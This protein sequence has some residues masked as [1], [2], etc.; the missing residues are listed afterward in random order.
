MDR[1]TAIAA[2]FAAAPRFEPGTDRAYSNSG[3]TLLAAVIEQVTGEEYRTAVRRRVFEPLGM[4]RSGLYGEPLWVDGNVAVGRGADLYQGNDPSRWPS[5]TWALIGNGGLV[6]TL[7][8]LMTLAKAFDDDS[9]F[10]SETRAAFRAVDTAGSIGGK[11]V[12]GYAGGNDFGFSAVIGQVL[13]D[14]TY[15]VAASHVLSP[16]TAEIL[17]VEVLQ[18]LYGEVLVLPESY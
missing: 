15:V 11:P 4:D 7:E 5:P 12:I 9:L 13:G 1:A 10:Q 18:A 17:G 6:S 8:D 3:Y 14:S 16:I 2:I